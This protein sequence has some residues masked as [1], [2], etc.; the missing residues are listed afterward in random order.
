MGRVRESKFKRD[1][2]MKH[3]CD[4]EEEQVTQD[5]RSQGCNREN[6]SGVTFKREEKN[7][8]FKIMC[9][10]KPEYECKRNPLEDLNTRM[11]RTTPDFLHV[12]FYCL[13]KNRT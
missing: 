7:R 9:C 11:T 6:N 8:L 1:K 12:L 4:I 5:L 3:N 10:C 2:K 13:V